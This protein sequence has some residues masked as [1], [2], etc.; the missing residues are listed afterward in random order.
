VLLT[1]LLLAFLATAEPPS[2]PAG[3][4]CVHVVGKGDTLEKIAGRH[5]VTVKALVASDPQLRKNPHLLHLGQRIEV[6]GARPKPRSAKGCGRGGTLVE[7]VVQPGETASSISLR[8]GIGTPEILRRN[9]SLKGDAGRLRSGQTLELCVGRQKLETSKLCEHRSPL[10]VHEVVPGEHLGA[11]AGRYGVRR[12]DL[13]KW[14]PGFDPD[15]ILPG[16]SLRVCPQIAPRHRDRVLHEVR[17]GDT[18]GSIARH[19]DTSRVTLERWQRGN[20]EDPNRL[21]PG[22]KLVVWVDGGI[23]AGFADV[24]DDAGVL[25]GGIQ[26]PSGSYYAVKSPSLAWGTAH[27]IRTIQEAVA[28]YA[29]RTTHAPP[30]H[31]GDI[32]KKGGGPFPPHASH[33]HGRD[34]DVGYV[35]RGELAK[36]P[37]FHRASARNLDVPRTWAL[38]RSFLETDEVVYVF[39][40]LQVQALLHEYARDHGV[41]DD[42]LD[43]WFQ[44]P[45]KHRHGIIQHWRGHV[46]H[47]HVRFVR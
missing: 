1:P 45:R 30:V 13:A 34:V 21:R 25:Q 44:Y 39:M 6:C 36:D 19:Y 46:D 20:L 27:T 18:F 7:H 17:S 9:P 23:V 37:K 33:Q 5:G 28:R 38:V 8:Y 3:V 2:T 14:N 12:R 35:L 16:Q 31:I 42:Q 10:Y 47:F 11:I 24:S 32:S 43:E 26:L 29:R 4:E 41:S 22:Q 15:R 40:D